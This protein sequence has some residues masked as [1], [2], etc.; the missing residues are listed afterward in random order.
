MTQENYHKKKTDTTM[1]KDIIKRLNPS[2][3]LDVGCGCGAFT[4]EISEFAGRVTAIDISQR[5]I[6]RCRR[7]IIKDNINFLSM[8]GLKME[9]PDSHF[10]IVIER[11]A[12]HHSPGW[13]NIIRE[14]LRVSSDLVLIEEPVDSDRSEAKIL[15]RKAWGYYLDLQRETGEYHAP[16]F[17]IS[18]LTGFLDKLDIRYRMKI[19][20]ND[21]PLS[22]DD[23]FS[24]FSRFAKIS[25]RPEYWLDRL[26]AFRNEISGQNLCKDDMLLL[27]IKK[28]A[29]I[30]D[31]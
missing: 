27:E 14:M 16:H 7:E 17:E 22:F 12:L 20:E 10:D 4:G 28:Q 21:N 9:F 25:K 24:L 11:C 15:K 18:T 19:K 2:N 1:I 3:I 29:C 13:K 6:E 26:E 5:H 31:I 30:I 23:F 8:S